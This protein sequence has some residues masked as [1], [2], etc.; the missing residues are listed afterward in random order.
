MNTE[1]RNVLVTI[2]EMYDEIFKA[3]QKVADYILK[4]PEKTIISNV[5][6]LANYSGV[7]DAT[8]IRL[9]KHLGFSG[10][11]EL[12]S[13]LAREIGQND[14]SATDDRKTLKSSVGAYFRT[15]GDRVAEIGSVVQED[16]FQRAVELL[17]RSS[18]VY[19]I[20]LGNTA[21]LAM[22]FGFRLERLGLCC[23]MNL[24]PEYFV[25]HINLAREGECVLAISR[26]GT[27]KSVIRA[28]EFAKEKG[29]KIIAVT[30][31]RYS[32]MT[33]LA[34]YVLLSFPDNTSV[35]KDSLS[36]LNETVVLDVLLDALEERLLPENALKETP[37][38]ILSSDKY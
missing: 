38:M 12:K 4:N 2:S 16:V 32:P 34:D 23:S 24:Q 18:R 20:A 29:L 25:N 10:Y 37:E 33:R 30:A 8:V 21:P 36:R 7:S 11:Y 19:S 27:T 35:E 1:K 14:H 6:E 15:M 3:E 9:C 26:T 17:C 31:Y 28:M 22:Y 5:S 13:S